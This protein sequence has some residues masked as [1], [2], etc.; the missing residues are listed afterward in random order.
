MG[1][2][3]CL[4]RFLKNPTFNNIQWEIEAVNDKAAKEHTPLWEI[5]TFNE[6]LNYIYYRYQY[7][8]FLVKAIRFIIHIK[9]KIKWKL[10]RLTN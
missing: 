4:E 2:T 5:P 9:N 1:L 3:N 8:I 7:A 10:K 6:R